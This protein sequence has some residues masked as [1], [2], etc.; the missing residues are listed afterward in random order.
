MVLE[1]YAVVE[2]THSIAIVGRVGSLDWLC[3]PRVGSGACFAGLLEGLN[4]GTIGNRSRRSLHVSAPS[5][6]RASSTPGAR[7]FR[8]EA[9]LTDRA[10]RLRSRDEGDCRRC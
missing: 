3:L 6:G 5:T 1:G 9:H 2:D 4:T 8:A 10:S 7:G